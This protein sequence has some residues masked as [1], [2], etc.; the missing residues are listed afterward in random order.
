MKKISLL[1]VLTLFLIGCQPT[2]T[3]YT[4]TYPEQ[5]TPEYCNEN[6][7]REYHLMYLHGATNVVGDTY[8]SHK[9]YWNYYFGLENIPLDDYLGVKAR[10]APFTVGPSI[11][12]NI[13]VVKNKNCE[14]DILF[15]CVAEKAELYIPDAVLGECVYLRDKKAEEIDQEVSEFGKIRISGDPIELTDAENIR[16]YIC[17]SIQNGNYYSGSQIE[18]YSGGSSDVL[19][20]ITFEKYDNLVWDAYIHTNINGE[21][22]I[23]LTQFGYIPIP[24]TIKDDVDKMISNVRAQSDE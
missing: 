4:M 3:L 20:R 22:Y 11:A 5:Y 23:L 7:E 10:P 15:D 24:D 6:Y 9:G 21:H 19:I 14:E 13:Y 16:Q 1:L 8:H 17:D 2:V 12:Y 18:V